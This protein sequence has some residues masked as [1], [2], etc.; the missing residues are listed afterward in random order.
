MAPKFATQQSIRRIKKKKSFFLFFS[1]LSPYPKLVEFHCV[2][3]S[4]IGVLFFIIVLGKDWNYC[5]TLGIHLGWLGGWGQRITNPIPINEKGWRR[6]V[7]TVIL[8]NRP[9][10]NAI[11][12]YP[13]FSSL[14]KNSTEHCCLNEIYQSCYLVTLSPTVTPWFVP[15]WKLSVCIYFFSQMNFP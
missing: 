13:A 5:I 1:F 12:M 10:G 4:S 3:F 14:K 6:K 15:C 11:T 2:C 9:S 7:Q 8:Q